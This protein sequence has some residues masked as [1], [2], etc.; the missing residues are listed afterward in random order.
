MEKIVRRKERVMPH[1]IRQRRVKRM[2]LDHKQYG[3]KP[4]QIDKEISLFGMKH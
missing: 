3:N 2:P 1:G 4:E